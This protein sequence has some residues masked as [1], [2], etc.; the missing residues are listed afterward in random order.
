Q[1]ACESRGERAATQ[2]HRGRAAPSGGRRSQQPGAR[3]AR[4]GAPAQAGQRRLHSL[5]VRL[6]G[7]CRFVFVPG[8]NP[9]FAE[10]IP[11]KS[12]LPRFA[13]ALFS[14]LATFASACSQPAAGPDGLL[15]IPTSVPTATLEPGLT[16][17]GGPT[18]LPAIPT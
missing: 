13:L 8:R 14:G 11:L 10:P 6:S 7:L 15:E 17:T 12:A 1:N 16:L 9:A 4:H 2:S 18:S 3:R 5:R